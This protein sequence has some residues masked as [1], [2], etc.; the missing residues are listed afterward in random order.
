MYPTSTE[1]V[2]MLACM[3]YAL[4]SVLP[5]LVKSACMLC[6]ANHDACL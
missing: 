5:A 1:L 2:A 6:L 3:Y 4:M